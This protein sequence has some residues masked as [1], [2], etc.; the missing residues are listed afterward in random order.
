MSGGWGE[1][2]TLLVLRF[3]NISEVWPPA[4][5]LQ[6]SRPGLEDMLYRP[7]FTGAPDDLRYDT[8]NFY[9]G[10]YFRGGQEFFYGD[11]RSMR[12]DNSAVSAIVTG[13]SAWTVYQYD[14]Y[15]GRAICAL[16]D[17]VK[18]ACQACI[19]LR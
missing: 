12:A 2:G 1:A 10:E 13:C 8:I 16:P 19:Q 18:D 7:V 5:G 9:L 4:S 11:A 14:Y 6:V 3:H 15:L 17:D